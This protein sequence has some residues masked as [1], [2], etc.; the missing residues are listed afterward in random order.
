M[1]PT[2][3]L[4]SR[5]LNRSFIVLFVAT[6]AALLWNQLGMTRR[7][8]LDA[9]SAYTVRNIDD[10][11]SG[12]RS[13]S[14]LRKTADGLAMDC[15]IRPGF[16][17]P[18]CTLVFELGRPPQGLDLSSYE[19]VEVSAAIDGPEPT[20][21]LRLFV[22][23]FNP[24]YSVATA[25]DSAKVQEFVYDP[26]LHPTLNARL[27]QFTVSSWWSNSHL[28]KVEH[29]GTEFD[30]VVAVQLSTG[31]NVQPGSH[32][33]TL[34]RIAFVGKWIPTSSLRLGVIA[35]WLLAGAVYLL[36]FV[37][38][39]RSELAATRYGKAALERMNRELRDEAGELKQ[40]A[41]RDALTGVLNRRGLR[42]ELA[43]AAGRGDDQ[44]F[45]LAIVFIDIDHFKRINDV[46]GHHVGDEVIRQMADVV[47]RAIQRDDILARW[48]GEEFLVFFPCTTLPDAQAIAE[49]LRRSLAQ[50]PWPHGQPVTGSFGVAQARAGDDLVDGIR[51]AD[52]AMYAAKCNGR[53]RVELED[54]GRPGVPSLPPSQ[55]A[56]R[57][58]ALVP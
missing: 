32:V 47:A 31:G 14:S 20:R 46:H 18:F 11:G 48:G 34:K 51:R 45:P 44:F 21:Q 39:V 53:N 52:E 17:W 41:R 35:L 57:Q 10:S 37:L 5:N 2:G 38:R 9:Q 29:I 25:P 56:D 26:S 8:V 42:D 22:L 54:A 16:A 4:S 33:L 28:L 7:T 43:H 13:S 19:T 49:R 58:D 27:G 40:A 50:H 24:A 6:L 23:N 3:L 36:A 15:E 1:P 30:N 55:P 12:G